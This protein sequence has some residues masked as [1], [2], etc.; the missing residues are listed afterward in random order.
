[1][2]IIDTNIIQTTKHSAG[3]SGEIVMMMSLQT[4]F[5]N[6]IYGLSFFYCWKYSL[7]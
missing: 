6:F 3:M 4:A 1:M 7:L 2:I 5:H